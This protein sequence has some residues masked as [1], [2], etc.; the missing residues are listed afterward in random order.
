L[1]HVLIVLALLLGGVVG[2]AIGFFGM[3]GL[4]WAYGKL[5]NNGLVLGLAALFGLVSAVVGLFVGASAAGLCA[6]RLAAAG[7]QRRVNVM[8]REQR[9]PHEH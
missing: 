4:G 9:K 7:E 8:T 1:K 2:A 5:T 3:L 6:C